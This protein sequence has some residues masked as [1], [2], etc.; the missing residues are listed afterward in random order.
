VKPD[1]NSLVINA[2]RVSYNLT[3]ADLTQ[4]IIDSF[5]ELSKSAISWRLHKLKTEGLIQSP[6]YGTYSLIT[7]ANFTPNVSSSLKRLYNRIAKEYPA[8]EMCVWDSKW[9]NEFLSESSET[10][11]IVAE[12]Q[13]EFSETV[14]NSLTDI[15]KK[16]FF[17]PSAEILARYITNLKDAIIIKP[18]ISESPCYEVENVRVASLE[19][20]LVDRLAEPEMFT[21]LNDIKSDLILENVI[22]KYN[23]S[24]SKMIRYSK[25]RNQHQNLSKLL[26]KIK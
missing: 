10:S 21:F 15:S 16:I 19:K 4:K 17:D 14:F 1:F 25:R 12:V 18:I 13:K 7:K 6:S 2:L 24:L 23:I 22:G 3:T 5:P 9:F 26:S 8:I 20:L 11:F